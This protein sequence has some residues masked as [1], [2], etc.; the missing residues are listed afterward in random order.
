MSIIR[1]TDSNEVVLAILLGV[2][3]GVFLAWILG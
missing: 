3:S 1:E 2:A